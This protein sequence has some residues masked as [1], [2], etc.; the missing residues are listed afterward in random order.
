MCIFI[1]GILAGW[2]NENTAAA[3]LVI[4]I[5]FFIYY[6]SHKW[7]IPVWAI[8][9]F[10]GAIIGFIIMIA[11]PGN[12]VR[13]GEST[14]F[15]LYNLSYRL[16]MWTLTF[17]YY[18]GPLFLI[19][20]ISVITFSRFSRGDK[21]DQ[22]EACA[23]ICSSCYCSSIRHAGF[24]YIPP[25]ST[26]RRCHV[27]YYCHSI[28]FYNLNYKRIFEANKTYRSI[29]IVDSLFIYLLSGLERN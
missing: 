16:F 13:A 1:P 26:F 21:K 12:F 22:N 2:T 14:S 5:G 11:A 18:S 8:A 9:G 27:P 24:T 20:L 17:F 6:R 28:C 29:S 15:S 10:T 7:A 19:T 25:Q 3:M 23:Y 4:V